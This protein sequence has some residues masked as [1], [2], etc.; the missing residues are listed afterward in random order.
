[1]ITEIFVLTLLFELM[2]VSGR[3]LFGPIKEF[4]K[5]KHV[6]VHIHHGYVGALLIVIGL[7]VKNDPS[8]ILG[9]ALFLSDAI[10]HF[11]VLPIWVK[12]TEFP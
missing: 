9:A 6:K 10:H 11:I 8:I 2:V 12:R 1:M 5:K 3:V 7:I 4:Y